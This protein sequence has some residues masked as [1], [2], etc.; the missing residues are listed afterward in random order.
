MIARPDP[1]CRG[2]VGFSPHAL[3]A[4]NRGDVEVSAWGWYGDRLDPV[5]RL[6]RVRGVGEGGT[7]RALGLG[8]PDLKRWAARLVAHCEGKVAIGFGG[9]LLI[10]IELTTTIL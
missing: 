8:T 4:S 3:I 10:N 9:R 5:H 2:I 1:A 6:I 7:T